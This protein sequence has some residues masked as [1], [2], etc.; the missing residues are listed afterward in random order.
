MDKAQAMCFTACL[1]QSWWEFCIM[2]A[3]YVYNRMPSLR[4]KWLTPFKMMN[5]EQPSVKHFCVL[6]CRTY[7]FI[8]EEVWQNKFTPKVE[9]IT[10][11]SYTEDIKR[12]IFMRSPNNVVFTA[13]QALFDETMFPKCP[14]FKQNQGNIPIGEL[15]PEDILPIED[16]S[17]SD[18][19]LPQAPPL[20][21]TVLPDIEDKSLSDMY[22][23]SPSNKGKMCQPWVEMELNSPVF[24]TS[25][26]TPSPWDRTSP[27]PANSPIRGKWI[28]DQQ[29]VDRTP[30]TLG[31]LHRG[32]FWNTPGGVQYPSII[33]D[34]NVPLPTWQPLSEEDPS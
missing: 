31:R 23:P 3:L 17:D 5:K 13:T 12:F 8:P 27:G 22:T 16:E 34:T 30:E 28:F 6:G 7:V 29:G 33:P 24:G 2:H 9:L 4:L 20:Q 11:L 25:L 26:R 21:R 14:D 10:F 1:P 19:G 15:T 18:R 32:N